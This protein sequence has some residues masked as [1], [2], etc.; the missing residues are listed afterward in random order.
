[1]IVKIE[2]YII[3]KYYIKIY[4]LLK[5][6]NTIMPKNKN[7]IKKNQQINKKESKEDKSIILDNYDS[8]SYSDDDIINTNPGKGNTFE[9]FLMDSDSDS[10]SDNNSDSDNDS[11][12]ENENESENEHE[13]KFDIREEE[14]KIKT[15]TKNGVEIEKS[16]IDGESSNKMNKKLL[17][18][19][20]KENKKEKNNGK[21]NNRND[22]DDGK[23]NLFVEDIEL[24]VDGKVL[25]NESNLVI[26]SNTMYSLIGAN[27]VGK[28]SLVK[29]IYEKL[30]DKE[31]VLLINQHINIENE[32]ETVYEYVLK[33]NEDMYYKQKE[34]DTLENK[35]EMTD[36]EMEKY[37][38]LSNYLLVNE[39]YKFN[40]EA[41]RI[42]NGMGF[43]D[44]N[45]KFSLFSGGFK[46]R[47]NLCRSLLRAPNLLILDEISNHLDL[48]GSL[49]LINYL[50]T[51]SKSLIIISHD[52]D[53]INSVSHV[54]WYVGDLELKGN[55]I[56]TIK[57]NYNNVLK[58]MEEISKEME[59]SYEQFQKKIK[60]LRNK[61]TPKKEVDEYIKNNFVPRPPKKY[62]VNITFDNVPSLPNS[63]IIQ[64]NDVKFNYSERE[65]FKKLNLSIYEGDKIVL[66][67]L[68]GTGKST[69]FNLCK[70]SIQPTE[71]YIL[72][73]DRLRI[74]YINQMIS[75]VLPLDL[76]PIQHLQNIDE[77]LSVG[78]CRGILGKLGISKR[79]D[80]RDLAMTEIKYLSGGE[81][82]RVGLS[83]EINI[84]RPH[85]ILFDE[86]T[87]HADIVTIDALINAINEFNGTCFVITHDSHFV[88]SIYNADLYEVKNKDIVKLNIDFDDYVDKIINEN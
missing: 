55:R 66:L 73:D 35:E 69:F 81:R 32:D 61:S 53:L 79:Q 62:E 77:R 83:S 9:G 30:K 72:K 33:A 13:Y 19:L 6:I 39:W 80:G 17:K 52:M 59:K 45:K 10:D 14:I 20:K 18:S 60:N 28:S 8:E 36:E 31:D 86:P 50:Q 23:S 64:F 71:G 44:I 42:L 67:G 48:N 12:S 11:D 68:N 34:L 27:G 78:D 41:K 51:Y 1:M 63:R 4:L 15:K 22:I 43:E 84:K 56:Y 47:G 82:F 49:F 2:D 38:E 85:V 65:I 40:A 70:G 21:I 3:F 26:N 24:I 16:K 58:K 57:G 74:S 37:E 75:D 88:R 87:N 54:I 7:K 25:I 29:Y 5:I 76:T 46:V